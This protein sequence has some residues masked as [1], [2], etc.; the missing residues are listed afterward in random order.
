MATF[1]SNLG[2]SKK[3]ESK[4][5]LVKAER[6]KQDNIT[7][8]VVLSSLLLLEPEEIIELIQKVK[9]FALVEIN[10]KELKVNIDVN[11]E[12][13]D[14]STVYGYIYEF[15]KNWDSTISMSNV[16][17]E[18]AHEDFFVFTNGEQTKKQVDKYIRQIE[19]IL[20]NFSVIKGKLHLDNRIAK[21]ETENL[22]ILEKEMETKF[23]QEAKEFNKQM[24]SQEEVVEKKAYVP[25]H[26]NSYRKLD[27]TEKLDSFSKCYFEGTCFKTD[28]RESKDGSTNY[29][30]WLEHEGNTLLVRKYSKKGEAG[31]P[32][33][34]HDTNRVYGQLKFSTYSKTYELTAYKVE[35]ISNDKFSKVEKD[36]SKDK[37]GEL[38]VHTNMSEMDATGKVDDYFELANYYGLKSLAF[39]DHNVVQSFPDIARAAKK[40]SNIKPIYG[41]EFDVYD[42]L[43]TKIVENEADIDLKTAEYVFFDI[44]TTGL[45][46]L[47]NEIIEFGA[48]KV[49]NGQVVDSM[50][51]FVK[52]N[53]PIPDYITKI[54]SITNDDVAKA[55]KI[56]L[57]IS[58]IKDFFGDAVLVAH[59]ASFDISFFNNL[60]KRF[61]LGKLTNPVL[62]TLKVS[63]LINK[64]L[65][66][67][68]LGTVARNLDISYDENIAHRA[69]YDSIILQKVYE[70]MLHVL[71]GKGI[72]NLKQ[73]NQH[74]FDIRENIFTLQATALVKN[75]AGL[76]D[77]YK[78][79][80][81]AHISHL[82]K[83]RKA[84]ML[85]LSKLMKMRNNL[86]IGAPANKG[87]IWEA[88]NYSSPNLDSLIRMFDYIEISPV[89]AFEHLVQGN[90]YN[91]KQ[92]KE[93]LRMIAFAA[94]ANNVPVVATSNAHYTTKLDKKIR[95]IYIA[96][97]S[98]G[99]RPHPLFNYDNPKAKNPDNHLRSTSEM[100]KE[101]MEVFPEKETYQYV[102]SNVNFIIDQIEKVDPIVKG[103]F[104]PKMQITNEEFTQMVWDGIS[105]IYGEHYDPLIKERIEKE[106]KSIVGHGYAIIYYLAH[107]V[108]KQSLSRGYLVG[109]RGSVGSSLVATAL[110]ITEVNPLIPHYLCENCKHHEF[111]PSVD[112]GFD[113]PTKRC[114]KC[115]AD[116]Y[117]E[118]H[119][120]PFETFLGFEGDKVPDIDLNFSGEIQIQMHDYV[121]E[122]VGEQNVF[123]AGSITTVEERNA[124]GFV[125]KY[126]ELLNEEESTSVTDIDYLVS[127][128]KGVKRTTGQHAGGVIVVPQDKEIYDFTPINYPSNDFENGWITTHFDFHTIHD[129]LLKLDL[130][131]HVDPTALKMLKDLTGVDPKEIKMN[132]PLV[133]SLFA[134]NHALNL[135][136]EMEEK[137]GAIGIPEFGTD[138]VRKMLLTA[139]PISF[140]DLIRVSGLSHG[141]NVWNGNAEQLIIDK[142]T[143]LKGVI[144]IR[145]DIMTYLISKGIENKTAF[146][147]TELVRK[148]NGKSDKFVEFEKIMRDHEVPEWYIESC[149]K[150]AYMFPK[151]H[152]TA[153]VIMAYRI[154]WYKINHPLEYYSTYLSTRKV[155][156]DVNALYKGAEGVIELINTYKERVKNRDKTLTDKDHKIKAT[157]DILVEFFARGYTIQHISLERSRASTWVIDHKTNSLIPPFDII[158]GFGEKAAE[159]LVEARNEMMFESLEDFKKRSGVNKTITE[160]FN[161]LG[162]LK[163]LPF[164]K[165]D[166]QSIFDFLEM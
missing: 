72:Y 99:G 32:I 86:L 53:H 21:F 74:I 67:H 111:D 17:V 7:Y 37:R 4:L 129:N 159:K 79:V 40:H 156:F 109:S 44:E 93:I 78:L 151:A 97:K 39:V 65:K 124:Y 34:E 25:K 16:V 123:R 70:N 147:I 160:K 47:V 115:G 22:A 23:S 117:G 71:Y 59:N 112:D 18:K 42:D 3:L 103:L 50:E 130:L 82:N 58:K 27:F 60:Y 36:L 152:A 144:S 158:D 30:Y 10:L 106:L 94:E 138:F 161:V 143:N 14:A 45:S 66:N 31:L 105:R 95:D 165:T 69:K 6:N 163:K 33:K 5:S 9:D 146:N 104:A 13:L 141:T 107:K 24:K 26:D 145:D 54:T 131:G 164:E 113:L 43:H 108:V 61:N 28:S 77:L 91:E 116:M 140:A 48:I 75:Q 96:S 8:N 85:P 98:V 155:E 157:C 134:S 68:R 125:K 12:E 142:T 29:F 126:V 19:N 20:K 162:I 133:I 120:I 114:P 15:L 64:D 118:G 90:K 49:R 132:D 38:H 83:R 139:K 35:F 101:M 80:S 121:K 150:I 154:A 110:E 122:L 41:V 62:D 102:I 56:D 119:N 63:W 11:Y 1:L 73:F 149:K 148:G 55:P 87:F 51:F 46:S 57:V 166:Q 52:P 135:K 81:D 84:P 137:T 89:S 153:Y 88:V 76:K 127:K 92:I 100:I 2:L 128:T 136:N